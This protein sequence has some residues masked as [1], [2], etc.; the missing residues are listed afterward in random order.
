M[1]GENGGKGGEDGADT[2]RLEEPKVARDFPDRLEG[3]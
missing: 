1:E 3:V 2:C